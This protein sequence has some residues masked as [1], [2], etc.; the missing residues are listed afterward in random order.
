MLSD[1]TITRYEYLT[2]TRDAALQ[3]ALCGQN[4]VFIG[5]RMIGLAEKAV[6]ERDAMTLEE[7]QQDYWTAL[8]SKLL[9]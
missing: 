5:D 4:P 8:E 1:T 2:N 3:V 6:Q 9:K 7:A